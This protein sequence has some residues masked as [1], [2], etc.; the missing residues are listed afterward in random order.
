MDYQI[1]GQTAFVS[2]GAHGIG[3]AI[4]NLLTQEGARV[5]VADQDE[6]GLNANA[7][8]WTGVVAAD[9][10]S[11]A[12]MDHAIKYVLETLGG[13]PDIL[14]NN[15]GVADATP[16]EDISDEQGAKSFQVNLMGAVRTCRALL[17]KMAERGSGAVVNTGFDLAKQ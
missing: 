9:L 14:I 2:A 6:S 1:Q 4:A 11:G 7:K 13:P 16:F 3:E 8:R 17:P 5:V 12:G 15:L 10:A